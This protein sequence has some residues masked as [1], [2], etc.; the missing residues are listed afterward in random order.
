MQKK[1]LSLLM[2]VSCGVMYCEEN[3][4][5]IS[6]EQYA[7]NMEKC[8]KLVASINTLSEQL[9]EQKKEKDAVAAILYNHDQRKIFREKLV[10]EFAAENDAEE[11]ALVSYKGYSDTHTDKIMQQKK[12]KHNGITCGWFYGIT[13]P[14]ANSETAKDYAR[15]GQEVK[16]KKNIDQKLCEEHIKYKKIAAAEVWQELNRDVV[17]RNNV[18]ELSYLPAFRRCNGLCDDEYYRC[19][20]TEGIN[21]EQVSE[22]FVE[23]FRMAAFIAAHQQAV[24]KGIPITLEEMIF[25]AKKN[26]VTKDPVAK[27]N[28]NAEV[29]KKA[30]KGELFSAISNTP[31]LKPHID[32]TGEE[33]PEI[34]LPLLDDPK[35]DQNN[36]GALSE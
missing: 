6:E 2:L 16:T 10:V 34:K 17:R 26:K 4:P 13:E 25:C 9:I 36:Q 15:F 32:L 19:L 31:E 3:L 35:E 18:I 7:E 20:G 23:N 27:L 22:N 33:K 21:K 24:K 12:E 1:L 29:L 14:L 8:E 11:K 30:I 5:V 28:A